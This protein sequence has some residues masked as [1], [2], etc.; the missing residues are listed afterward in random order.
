MNLT[1]DFLLKKP[2]RVRMRGDRAEF[3]LSV[4]KLPCGNISARAYPIY[5]SRPEQNDH[6]LLTDSSNDNWFKELELATDPCRFDRELVEY[7]D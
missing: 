3:N 5:A 7:N 4:I 6:L 1:L 2:R